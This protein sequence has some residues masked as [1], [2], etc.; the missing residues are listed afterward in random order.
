MHNITS[1]WGELWITDNPL[2]ENIEALENIALASYYDLYIINNP[3]LSQCDINNI[4]EYLVDPTGTIEI[5]DNAPG[6]NSPEE[7]EEA[8]LHIFVPEYDAKTEFSITPNPFKSSALVEYTLCQMSQVT[9]QIHDLSG[10]VIISSVN[11]LQAAGRYS[12]VVDGDS[13]Q[14]GVYF[15]ILKT[16]KGIQTKKMIKL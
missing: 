2:L 5:Y 1:I 10:R 16:N 11:E 9:L 3:M 14:S 4:C 13:F 15:C 12:I 8:C 6:C 7:V